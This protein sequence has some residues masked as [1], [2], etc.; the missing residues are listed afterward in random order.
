MF[1]RHFSYTS[2]LFRKQKFLKAFIFFL[3]LNFLI[4]LKFPHPKKKSFEETRPFVQSKHRSILRLPSDLR[5]PLYR[6]PTTNS[7]TRAN[8]VVV[9]LTRERELWQL[10]LVL[11]SFEKKFNRSLTKCVFS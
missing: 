11:D 9:I 6:F 8:G 5:A 7:T 1:Q 3:F 4:Y 10:K 2:V